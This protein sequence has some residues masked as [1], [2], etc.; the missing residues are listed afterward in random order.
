MTNSR[1]LL[2]IAFTFPPLAGPGPR[3]NL[4]TVRGLVAA[5]FLPTVITA[6]E[7]FQDPSK[8]KKW[9]DEYLRTRIPKDVTIIPFTR[10]FKGHD[11]LN[12]ILS[13]LGFTPVPYS[14]RRG[15]VALYDVCRRALDATHHEIIY[16]VNGFGLEHP[17]ALQ[18]K[19]RTGLPWIAEFRDPW[20]YNLTEWYGIRDGS[21]QWWCRRQYNKTKQILSEIVNNADLIVV[22]SPMHGELLT[23]D[24]E[25]DP[26]KVAPLGI[27]YESDYLS[28]IR[29]G[30]VRFPTRP[31]IG[32]IGQVWYGYQHAI[33]NL[34]EALGV[35]EREG[36][37]F[38]LVSVGDPDN[39]FYRFAREAKLTNFVPIRNVD[40]LSALSIM[41]ELDFGIVAT[42][43]KCLPTINSKLWEYL[44]LNQSILGIVP[45][46]GSM[47]AIIDEGNC[48]YVLPYD[49]ESMVYSLR[50]ALDDHKRGKTRRANVD[51]VRRYS[52]KIMVARLIER[53]DE[54]LPAQTTPPLP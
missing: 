32:F 9:P 50:K 52:R 42:C 53:L 40:Y 21:W 34:T 22:E 8:P 36:H 38:T 46:A 37:Q 16:S 11:A 12:S 33:R 7:A 49:S 1:R 29:E 41:S 30:F 6:P 48:G 47:A 19:R 10:S 23:K 51:F 20:I 54:L 39:T 35:L 26:Q 3:H 27:G 15:R 45:K 43:E 28:D 25:L 44:A 31:V 13:P 2:Y 18:L 4:S 14:F 5:G 24:F 17:A